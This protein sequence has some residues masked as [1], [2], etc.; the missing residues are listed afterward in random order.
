MLRLINNLRPE[1]I[2]NRKR[3][4]PTMLLCFSEIYDIVFNNFKMASIFDV[5]VSSD[6][7]EDVNFVPTEDVALSEG[8]D[9]SEGELEAAKP[10][11]GK[12][13]K[14]INE[15]KKEVEE[16][17]VANVSDPK[18]LNVDPKKHADDIWKSFLSD[19]EATS[20]TKPSTAVSADVTNNIV[21]TIAT[22]PV[23]STS[24]KEPTAGVFE[25]AGE[26][27]TAD[28]NFIPISSLEKAKVAESATPTEAKVGLPRKR[29]GIDSVLGTLSN[30]KQKMTTLQKTLYDWK[31]FKTSEGI[32]EDLEKFNKGRG[33]F[34]ERQR[35]LQRSDVRSFEVEKNIRQSRKKK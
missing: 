34:I 21:S 31:S 2:G 1:E 17:E 11:R 10:K 20:A 14:S 3:S 13:K 12:M 19:V 5:S 33:G 9:S 18:D 23:E 24:K 22:V 27:F 8:E 6:S 26:T 28:N 32:E 15:S 25:F 16:M 7:E 29:G 30:K 35:F 4:Q